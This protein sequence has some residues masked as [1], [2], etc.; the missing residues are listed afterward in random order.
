MEK[1]YRVGLYCRLS[2]DDAHNSAKTK[3]YIPADESASIENQREM[4]SKFVMVNGWVETKTYID[5]GYS[6]ANFQRPGFQEMLEDARK[7]V[8]NLILVKDLSRLGRDFVEVGRYTSDVF[9]SLGVRFVSV[10]DCL[11]TEG[12]NTDMLHFR[13]LM[14]DYHLRDLS[15]KVRS[16][17][18]S[19]K[20]SGQF[21]S[22]YAPYGYRKSDED[23]HKLVIDEYAAGVVR[24]IFD[25]RASGMSYGKITATL[26]Q[27]AI[28]SPR[29]Y[30]NQ[31]TGKEGRK[32]SPL[33]SCATVKHLLQND[34]YLGNLRMNHTG[35]RSYKDSTQISK[36]ESEWIRIKNAH[37]P[38]I[39]RE[40]WDAVQEIN[41]AAFDRYKD[42]REATPKLFS[43]KLICADCKG[44]LVAGTETK[45]KG[46][47]SVKRYVSYYCSRHLHSGRT[48]CSWHRIYEN[49]LARIVLADIREQA[50]KITVD[51]SAIE[52][53]LMRKLSG[54]AERADGLRRE[55]SQLQRDIQK[56][57]DM[58][59]K[60]YEDKMNGVIGAD[61]FVVL[62]RK[63]ER[64]RQT[65]QERLDAI[66]PDIIKAGADAYAV[67]GWMGSV[68][69]YLDLQELDRAIV[70]ELIDRIEIGER[71][72]VDGQRRQEIRVFYRFVG[73]LD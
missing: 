55:A 3:N 34:V 7:G 19:K 41:R 1:L 69:K 32:V 62:M 43:G 60:L 50:R 44:P 28:P 49:T 5:D 13:S 24:R 73:L 16:I 25:M 40:T 12:D 9:P 17:L 23:K 6:G 2:V 64:E 47:S 27:E 61:A 37:E 14:N 63:N 70:D 39:T 20:A 51:E 31:Q 15:G 42:N 53:K 58:T 22:A 29:Y 8:I 56:L 46:Y 33:W 52:E 35:T 38:V 67:R 57:E 59:A 45:R 71:A 65:K 4:L 21:T 11:D 72:V 30:W 10:L 18:H 66:L 36:P 68:R 26:N 48:V 54:D